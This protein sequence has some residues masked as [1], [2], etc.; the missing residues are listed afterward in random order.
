MKFTVSQK[1]SGLSMCLWYTYTYIYI[2]NQQFNHAKIY[3]IRDAKE[4]FPYSNCWNNSNCF[5]FILF[6]NSLSNNDPHVFLARKIK[7]EFSGECYRLLKVRL[8]NYLMSS[9]LL[10]FHTLLKAQY[11]SLDLKSSTPVLQASYNFFS[12]NSWRETALTF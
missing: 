7:K 8:I 5:I 1:L 2:Y 6:N 4:M 9:H 12:N 10:Q 3:H 11:R